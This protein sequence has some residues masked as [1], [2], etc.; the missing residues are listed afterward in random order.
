LSQIQT[1]TDYG[2]LSQCGLIIE[3]VTENISMKHEVFSRLNTVASQ[4]AL[5]ATNT[6]GISVHEIGKV[7]A[8]P[9]RLLGLHFFNP[10]PL[11]KLVEV[12]C[13]RGL[14]DGA[15]ARVK[16]FCLDIGKEPVVVK[17]RPGFLVNRLLIPYL[18]QVANAF[19]DGLATREDI[20]VAIEL[21]LRYPMGPL[22]LMDQIGLDVH[23]AATTTIYEQTFWPEFRP[24]AILKE[25]V[26]QGWLGRKSGKGFYE[27]R[28]EKRHE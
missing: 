10:V 7:L 5:L 22:K 26:D 27:F 24:P 17:D 16:Q 14:P 23:L 18:N 3:A 8:Q 28:E 25:Y 12:V 20:D 4:D 15:L 1:T 6:S 19:D 21:G 2:D 9:E 13:P 11:M